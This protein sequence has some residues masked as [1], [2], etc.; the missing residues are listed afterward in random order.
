MTE[1]PKHVVVKKEERRGRPK[2]VQPAAVAA[3]KTD[4]HDLFSAPQH[5]TAIQKNFSV[6]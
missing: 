4:S 1:T 5:F 6:L 2:K 3:K